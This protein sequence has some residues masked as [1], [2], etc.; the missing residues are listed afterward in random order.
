MS[1]LKIIENKCNSGKTRHIDIRYNLI[2]EL[3]DAGEIKAVHLSTDHM[4]ADI[5]TKVLSAGPFKFLRNF[6]LG[7][8][9]L[10]EFDNEF[11]QSVN[12][13]QQ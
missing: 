7:Y 12:N 6:L 4:I 11:S 5:N 1:T 9:T 3:I 8:A 13:L 2:R 10:K